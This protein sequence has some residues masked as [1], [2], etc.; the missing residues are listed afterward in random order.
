MKFET[1]KQKLAILRLLYKI[2]WE[3]GLKEY[4]IYGTCPFF[5]EILSDFLNEIII[6]NDDKN[7]SNKKYQHFL[8]VIENRL[9]SIEKLQY[10]E[11]P[12][13]NLNDYNWIFEDNWR[14][15]FF[16]SIDK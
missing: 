16:D 1:N 7:I 14:D 12:E 15:Y 8:N 2:E 11:T 6:L 13:I 3:G 10:L 5:D 4:C 9:G